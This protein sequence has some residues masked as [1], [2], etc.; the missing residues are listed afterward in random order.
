ML[1][2]LLLRGRNSRKRFR[3]SI[4]RFVAHTFKYLLGN[5]T[6]GNS[7]LGGGTTLLRF[8]VLSTT[9]MFW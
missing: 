8:A 6:I 2:E 3:F 1:V 5:P 4:L 7:A 9:I